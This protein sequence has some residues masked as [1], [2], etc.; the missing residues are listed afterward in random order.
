MFFFLFL[1]LSLFSFFLLMPSTF[2]HC[3]VGSV[4]CKKCRSG[5]GLGETHFALISIYIY[6]N[7]LHPCRRR[8]LLFFPLFFYV[9]SSCLVDSG[10]P[11]S[12]GAGEKVS[13]LL[14]F[15]AL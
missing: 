1:S 4:E 15:D 13:I 2:F 11:A 3:L 10:I 5:G 9:I 14:F 6:S 7:S 12:A 8:R